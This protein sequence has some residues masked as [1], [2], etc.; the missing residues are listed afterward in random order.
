MKLR[1]IAFAVL[2]SGLVLGMS[3]SAFATSYE[4]WHYNKFGYYPL[5]DISHWLED[6]AYYVYLD[7]NSTVYDYDGSGYDYNDSSDYYVYYDYSYS[8]LSKYY[9]EVTDAYWSGN[10]AKWDVDGKAS[11][12]QIRVYRDGSRINTHD[13]KS[14]SYSLAS[15]IS[16]E[17]YYYFEVRAYNSNSGWSSWAESEDKYYS[18]QAASSAA[19]GSSTAAIMMIGPGGTVS[20]AQWIQATD[21][22]GRWWYKHA[23]GSFTSNGWES[24]NGKWY[25]FDAAGWMKT[26]WLA[27]GGSTY[28][29]GSDG[30]MVTGMNYID[31]ANHN[32][33]SSGRML[34]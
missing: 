11:K 26:G 7:E 2:A 8:D 4:E 22:T 21:G 25:Y 3:M 15:D 29:L 32:F 24:I 30:A 19:S 23:D 12:Y 34:Y 17:G 16:K 18:P 27:V 1:R 9:A 20:Q 6:P 14:K 28:Y 33:D 10:T 5:G 31:G 13:T